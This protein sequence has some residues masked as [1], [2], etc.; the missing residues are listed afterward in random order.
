MRK[1]MSVVVAMMLGLLVVPVSGAVLVDDAQT[2]G[3]W[4]MDSTYADNDQVFVPDDNS[5]TGRTAFDLELTAEWSGLGD[6]ALTTGNGGKYGE[7]LVFDTDY[8]LVRD[9]WNAYDSVVLDFWMNVDE[10]PTTSGASVSYL[11]RTGPWDL[12]INGDNKMQWTVRNSGGSGVGYLR[13]DL[14]GLEDQWIHVVATFSPDLSM[15]LSVNDSTVE[16]T[17]S[18]MWWLRPDD[19]LQVGYLTGKPSNRAFKGMLD[20]VKISVVPEPGTMVLLGLG[21]LGLRR[22]F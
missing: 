12:V 13:Q 10:L 7:A 21:L 8:A 5:V 17:A 14:S 20:E 16:T 4:H 2:I 9:V 3:L 19:D 11:F 15:S 22:K 18:A 1:M 6:P